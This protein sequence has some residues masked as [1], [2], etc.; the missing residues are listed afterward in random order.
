MLTR[1]GRRASRAFWRG[2]ARIGARPLAAL[3]LV[4]VVT[5]LLYALPPILGHRRPAIVHDEISYL[6]AANTFRHGRLTNPSPPFWE[7]FEAFHQ[8]V[9]PT[10]QSKFPPGQGL[11]L[12]IGWM[13]GS[14][15]VGA[16]LA[17]ALAAS[18]TT[19]MIRA[20]ASWRLAIV[21]GIVAGLLPSV[22]DWTQ[23]FWGGSLAMAGA[24]LFG[25]AV[26]RVLSRSGTSSRARPTPPPAPSPGGEEKDG[27][28]ATFDIWK[29]GVI[30]GIGLSMLANTRPFEGVLLAIMVFVALLTRSMLR[31]RRASA[32]FIVGASLALLPVAAWMGYYNYRATGNALQMPYALHA[33]QYMFAPIF[34]WDGPQ[35]PTRTENLYITA[36]HR[37]TEFREYDAQR[38]F[39]GFTKLAVQR[40]GLILMEAMYPLVGIVALTGGIV[41]LRRSRTARLA[42]L[43]PIVFIA[44]H[45]AMTPWLRAHY[46][47]PVV[48]FWVM[49]VACAIR[50]SRRIHTSLVPAVSIALVIASAIYSIR[51]SIVETK[52]IS[53]APDYRRDALA[54][55]EQTPGK[56]IVVV[57]HQPGARTETQWVHNPADMHNARVLFVH[58]RDA[59]TNSALVNHFADR[60]VWT[61]SVS[62]DGVSIDLVAPRN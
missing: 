3:S 6:L 20:R 10:Y 48:P 52:A 46:L 54:A 22:F 13:L 29:N 9:T 50:A 14:P 7:S 16:I 12:A 62:R 19:W 59:A 42:V 30:A 2:L 25:G 58:A 56:H 44:L 33:R 57:R 31:E 24:A 1:P 61:A 26:L 40:V 41:A 60:S 37:E 51:A 47:A 39:A 21:S 28:S 23:T 45:L 15:R 32:R 49:F 43:I 34:W 55:I 4:F 5:S 17:G 38:T 8:I 27:E 36:F 53:A 11:I 35:Q 18:A